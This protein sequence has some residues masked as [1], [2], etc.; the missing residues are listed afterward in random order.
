MMILLAKHMQEK[1]AA[2]SHQNIGVG[3]LS[4]PAFVG[5]DKIVRDFLAQRPSA[6]VSPMDLILAWLIGSDTLVRFF[7]Q[8]C[9]PCV[10]SS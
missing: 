7:D 3:I 5:K 6:G 1:A 8:R 4:E 10:F 2:P 9:K